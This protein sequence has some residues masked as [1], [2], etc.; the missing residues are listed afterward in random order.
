MSTVQPPPPAFEGTEQISRE[1]IVLRR[2]S[3][4]VAREVRRIRAEMVE[5]INRIDSHFSSKDNLP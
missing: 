1:V 3:R 4:R 5:L 2:R